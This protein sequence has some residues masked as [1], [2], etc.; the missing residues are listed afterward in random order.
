[1]LSLAITP[2]AAARRLVSK[3]LSVTLL[4]VGFALTAAVGG[5]VASL[6]SGTIK[7]S[8]FV[9]IISFAIYL[10]ARIVGPT[11]SA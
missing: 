9:T 5:I 10:F 1:M 11:R 3:P 4:A 7:P 2:A 8:I 6:A